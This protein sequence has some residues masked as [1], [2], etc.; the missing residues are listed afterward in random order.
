LKSPGRYKKEIR[1]LNSRE[2]VIS[3]FL[4]KEADR[5]PVSELYINSPVASKVLGR[6]A[7]TGWSGY[8]RCGVLNSMLI[9]GRGEEF[10]LQEAVDVV[11]LYDKL[12][13]DTVLIE[14]PPL[15]NFA[16]PVAVDD[17]TWRFDDKKNNMF[18]I[19]HFDKKTDLFHTSDSN[20]HRGGLAEFER[21]VNILEK[22]DIDL[23]KYNWGQAEYIMQKCAGRK[24]VMAVVEIDFPP[25]SMG[26]IGRFFLEA[27]AFRSD[28]VERYLDYRVRKGLKFIEKYASMGVDAIFDGEDLAGNNGSLFSPKD[29]MKYYASRFKIL[30]EAVHEHGMY[31]LRHTDGNITGFADEFLLE[32][33]FDGYHSIDPEAGMDLKWVKEKYGDKVLLMG[34]VDCG[35]VLHLGTKEDVIKD[36]LRAIKTASPGGGHIVSSSNTIHSDVPYDNYMQ[37]LETVRKYGQYPIQ[38]DQ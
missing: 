27:M 7:Y 29:Y 38:I 20:F 3:A 17:T 16:I 9:D 11:E 22:D 28:L 30:A 31:Y 15:K 10:F 1:D 35:R 13:L 32:S 33:G 24:F 34:N 37:M 36:T 19:V 25:M 8:I 4:H 18:S 23:Q 6:L 5:V 21:F 26:A 14:R 2:R 12:E